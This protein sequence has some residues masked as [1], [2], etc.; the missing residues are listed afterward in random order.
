MW[1][2]EGLQL[3]SAGSDGQCKI[4]NVKKST[5]LNT[6]DEHEDKIWAMD[7]V[8]DKLITGGSDSKLIEWRDV[9]KEVE[10]EEY[11]EKADRS[12]EEHILS[13]MIYEG[14]FKE[15]AIQAFKLKKNRD[16]FTV[17]EMIL[18][19]TKETTGD[20]MG[21][22][23]DPV[24]AVLNNEKKFES[25]FQGTQVKETLTDSS[26]KAELLVKE[27]VQ[28]MLKL[29]SIRL[30][31]TIRDLNVHQKYWKIAQLLLF[32]IFKLF[33]LTKF[34]DFIEKQ[35][36][37]QNEELK[38]KDPKNYQAVSRKAMIARI[39]EYLSIISFYSQKHLERTERYQKLS[40]LVNFV[41]SKYTVEQEK[42]QLKEQFETENFESKLKK[43][44]RKAL[45]KATEIKV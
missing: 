37:A 34:I 40:Y 26:S 12:K 44:D 25:Q 2:N 4:W 23:K 1:I 22:T 29:D 6:F 45:A 17:I 36:K 13:S 43:R 11:K 9:T 14:R 15:A 39:K 41:I 35:F 5:C 19:Q 20:V 30:L 3:F 28:E 31:E 7:S 27:I 8:G 24:M 10:D 18:D 42:A 33:G 32:Q 21:A 16:L 38:L